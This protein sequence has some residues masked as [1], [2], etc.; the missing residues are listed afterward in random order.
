MDASTRFDT[1]I[2]GGLPVIANYLDQLTVADTIDRLVPWQGNV[3]LGAV[4]EV[5]IVNRLPA[6]MPLFRIDAWA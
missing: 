5:M 4:V 1:Q 3:P 6:P 2:V